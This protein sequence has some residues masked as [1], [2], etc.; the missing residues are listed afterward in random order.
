MLHYNYTKTV[1]SK[2]VLWK[3]IKNTVNF[4]S[5]AV[6]TIQRHKKDCRAKYIS[7][8]AFKCLL[9]FLHFW[10]EVHWNPSAIDSEA[11][12]PLSVLHSKLKFEW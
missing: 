2:K 5:T 11:I 1:F 3:C 7:K 9:N 12:E 6:H 4:A 8:F 10:R